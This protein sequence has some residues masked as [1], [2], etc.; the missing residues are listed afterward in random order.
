M[1]LFLFVWTCT[2]ANSFAQPELTNLAKEEQNPISTMEQ[3]GLRYFSYTGAGINGDQKPSLLTLHLSIPYR[4]ND[5]WNVITQAD[6]P[7][8][9]WQYGSN[10]YS[11]AGNLLM[12][13]YFSPRKS[14]VIWGVGPVVQFPTASNHVFDNG[15][16]AAGP[17]FAIVRKK[18][19][20]LNAI[21]GYHLWQVGGR[22]DSP[23]MNTTAVQLALNYNLTKG[24]AVTLGSGVVVDWRIAQGEKSI[25]PVGLTIGHTIIPRRGGNPISCNVGASYNV[26]RPVGAPQ[27]QYKFQI[28]FL[29]PQRT[30]DSPKRPAKPKEL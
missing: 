22:E 27:F 8:T 2:P 20:W 3:F 15:Q 25:V 17:A 7:F 6:M 12:S 21:Q 5:D 19:R 24:W 1:V 23:A 28:T 4:L 16:Y 13:M 18:G 30:V 29:I 10:N 14:S 9:S 11:G 26:V